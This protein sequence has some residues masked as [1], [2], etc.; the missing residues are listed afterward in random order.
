[1][2]STLGGSA[3]RN[4]RSFG[5]DELTGLRRLSGRGFFPGG[6]FRRE[7]MGMDKAEAGQYQYGNT[8]SACR[9]VRM[10]THRG[11]LPFG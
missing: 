8:V 1:M 11:H 2:S 9:E 5:V 4:A 6:S 10:R 3:P 7:G